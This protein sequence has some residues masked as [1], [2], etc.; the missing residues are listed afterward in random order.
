[1]RFLAPGQIEWPKMEDCWQQ[2]T[3]G[4]FHD[5]QPLEMNIVNPQR[6]LDKW[7][8]SVQMEQPWR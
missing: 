8:L 5:S 1:M 6:Q 2:V 3:H 4:I 7:P